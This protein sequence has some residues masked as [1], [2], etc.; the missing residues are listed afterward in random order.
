MGILCDSLTRGRLN[1]D[2]IVENIN[3]FFQGM[4]IR[5]IGVDEIKEKIRTRVASGQVAD[6]EGWK[7][8]INDEIYNSE[9]GK[10]SR[11]LVGEAMQDAKANYNDQTLPLLALLFL[12]NSDRDNFLN[13]FKAV[14]LAKRGQ[15]A[16]NDIRNVVNAG[17]QGGILAGIA[18]GLGAIKNVQGAVHQAANPSLVRR[19][20]LKNLMSYYVN[21][22]TLLPVNI[23]AKHNEGIPMKG[24]FTKVLNNAFNKNVQNNYVE[25]TLFANYNN[26]EEINVEQFF[27]DHYLTLKN[28]NGLRK[29]LVTNYINSLSPTDIFKIISGN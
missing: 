28:D 14:N 24:Y 4:L 16:G 2:Q 3:K 23:L 25:Q 7:T 17:R 11:E 18:T 29:G 6:I 27:G 1:A 26:Q 12:T 13:A 22:L 15:S 10:T 19:E 21:F 9:Y 20:D 5:Q 8:F